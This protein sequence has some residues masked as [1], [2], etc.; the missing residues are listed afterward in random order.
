MIRCEIPIAGPA[1]RLLAHGLNL[2]TPVL[3][4]LGDGAL[5]IGGLAVAAWLTA[6]PVAR[7]IRATR[8][9]DLGI[10]RV[11]LGLK[12]RRTL[13]ADLLAEH[14]FQAG[15]SE[16]AFRFARETGEGSFVV[17]L[18]VAPG[19]SRVQPPI[20]EP[21]L[22]TL[23]A[24]G[25]AY[26][27]LRGPVGLQLTLTGD[28]PTSFRLRTVQLDAAFVLKAALMAAGVR[29]RYDRR[30]TD[31]AD[32]LMLASACSSDPEATSALASNRKRSDVKAAVAWLRRD[33]EQK[34][35]AGAHRISRHFDDPS[36][37]EWAVE[38]TEMF[39][40]ALDEATKR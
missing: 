16:E 15:Y 22:P 11:A 8:D 18:L 7:P 4:E 32:A 23:A 12:G 17:D 13:V 38:V 28:E 34:T 27:L 10:D 20:I 26:A 40:A 35:S 30:I 36:A 2:L 29:T 6:R 19:A 1:D 14:D 5:L 31:T 9:V 3:D 33:F 37:A 39:L 25:L 21:G 24:P